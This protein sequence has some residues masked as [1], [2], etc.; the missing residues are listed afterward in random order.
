MLEYEWPGDVRKPR[1]ALERALV[2]GNGQ[3]I[4]LEDLPFPCDIQISSPGDLIIRVASIR[5]SIP[6][7]FF[8]VSSSH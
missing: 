1:N 6:Q 3:E 2:M 7:D 5:F 8:Y 4:L